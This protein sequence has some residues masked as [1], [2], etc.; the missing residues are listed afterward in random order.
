MRL[1]ALFVGLLCSFTSFG[2]YSRHLNPLYDTEG[3][4]YHPRGLHVAAGMT[5][6][7]PND[8]SRQ[9]TFDMDSNEEFKG[10]IDAGGRVGLYLEFGHA[11]FL[12]HWMP[13]EYIDYGIGFKMLRGTEELSG[14]RRNEE[15]GTAMELIDRKAQFT[16]NFATAYLNFSKFIQLKDDQFITIGL[17]LNGDY[18]LTT[19]I[20]EQS[21]TI[22]PLEFTEDFIL[23][24]HLK[25]GYGFKLQENL[26]FLPSIETPLITALP[27]ENG[28]STLPYYHTRYRPF[29][30]S[31]RFQ[32]LTRKKPEDCVGKPDKKRGHHLW[33]PK[34]R[35]K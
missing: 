19:D 34:M 32:W 17:G 10:D 4:Y 1:V 27:F 35:R 5:Y 9:A 11:H 21:Q 13:I 25:I 20:P 26:F 30:L 22:E 24:G 14:I 2:Q 31:L 15:T 8:Y 29:I 23:Q 16:E 12:P 28:K 33:D 18:K 7:M 6:L 3:G